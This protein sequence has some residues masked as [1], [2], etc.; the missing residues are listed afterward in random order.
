MRD[1]E[2]ISDNGSAPIMLARAP[3]QVADQG[4]GTG[5]VVFRGGRAGNPNFDPSTG[6]FSGQ[7]GRGSL[8]VVA[9]TVQAGALPAIS[10][11]PKGADPLAW[12]RR[13]DLVRDAS[14]QMELMD[15][16]SAR[17]YLDGRVIDISQ[18]NIDSFVAD[19]RMQ[20]IAD[21]VDSLDTTVRSRK[22]K[23]PVKVITQ[24]GWR[25]RALAGLNAAEVGHLVSRLE[26]LGW[27][28]ADIKTNIVAKI[29]DP[30]IKSHLQQLYGEAAP[31]SGKKE[32][33]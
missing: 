13:L 17:K 30:E 12:Q 20:R 14:R 11:L 16:T 26:G 24:S 33:K 25:S 1:Y 5:A 18:V 9:Q 21:L 29:K 15:V 28:P 10:T 2:I 23:L 6:R 19:V 8:Q 27:D 22:E 3:G 7:G 4:P 32:K 31:K